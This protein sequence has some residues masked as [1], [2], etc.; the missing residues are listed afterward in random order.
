MTGNPIADQRNAEAALA[1]R[2]AEV[3]QAER[4]TPGLLYG[5]GS[6]DYIDPR[7]SETEQR[8]RQMEIAEQRI[9]DM[10]QARDATI[11]QTQA[12]DAAL[13][14]NGLPTDEARNRAMEPYAERRTTLNQRNA[15]M[16]IASEQEAARDAAKAAGV[17]RTDA[18]ARAQ[19]EDSRLRDINA[20]DNAAADA[21]DARAYDRVVKAAELNAKSRE[22]DYG[23]EKLLDARARLAQS[24]SNA[25]KTPEEI[26]E[27]LDQ[28]FPMPTNPADVIAKAQGAPATRK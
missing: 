16:A 17:A 9:E 1:A 15:N 19:M 2:Q 20:E 18:M 13:A 22:R 10:R 3:M 26:Q 8:A 25:M 23:T 6:R 24:L 14:Y 5:P 28:V 11:A 12:R 4:N 7:L 21:R 27:I